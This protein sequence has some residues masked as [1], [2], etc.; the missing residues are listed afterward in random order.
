MLVVQPVDAT[1]LAENPEMEEEA[2]DGG[3]TITVELLM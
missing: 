3:S 2:N 1:Q